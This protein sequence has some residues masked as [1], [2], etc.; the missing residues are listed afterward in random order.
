MPHQQRRAPLEPQSCGWSRA[1]WWAALM[2]SQGA[3][4]GVARRV[5]VVVARRIAPHLG[6]S[7]PSA[8]QAVAR[9]VAVVAVVRAVAAVRAVAL[10]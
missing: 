2:G 4:A 6:V 7:Q 3:G 10:W 1:V 9:A 8:A 5:V